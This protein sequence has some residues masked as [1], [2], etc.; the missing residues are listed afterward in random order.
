MIVPRLVFAAKSKST[1]TSEEALQAT[2]EVSQTIQEVGMKL[3]DISEISLQEV[4]SSKYLKNILKKNEFKLTSEGTS[5]VPTAFIA[6]YG[7]GAPVLG[8][9]LEYDA[10]PGLGNE[11]VPYKQ[12]RKDHITSGHGCGHNLIGAGALGAALALKNLM[13]EKEISGTLRVY[14]GAAEETEGAKVY[15]ARDRLFDDVD[16]MLHWHPLNV[17]GVANIR[18]AALSQMYIE[19]SGKAAHAGL[20]PWDGRN[21][22]AAVEIFLHSVNMMREHIRPTARI[23]Y[24]IK[25]GGEAPNIV[26]DKASVL[27]TCRDENREYVEKS[28]V[29]LKSMAEGAALATQTEA[30]A[31]DYY[32]VHDLLPNT[33]LAERMQHHLEKIG[34]PQYTKQEIKFAKRLQ[35]EAGLEETGMTKDIM[36]LP[37]EQTLGGGTDVGDVSWQTPTMGL[38]MPAS[39]EGIGVHTWMATASHGSSIGTKAAIASAKV[40]TLMG[41]DLLLDNKLLKQV[42]DDFLKRTKG[43]VYQSPINPAIKE[44]VSLPKSMRSYESALELKNS[45]YKQA[46]DDQFMPTE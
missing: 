7:T 39:P 46:G 32:G 21:A 22:L 36:F 1:V 28:V 29:W 27:L 16:T 10:L 12:P 43:F 15:M 4:E 20:N 33:P 45:F 13:K 18:S 35:K 5:H 3:W 9:M 2:E 23:H 37:N 11:A 6:E 24:I 41:I 42:K 26:P 40:L 34:V 8:I 25:N 14:G 44:P 19:F 31:V 30:L 38:I 17:A